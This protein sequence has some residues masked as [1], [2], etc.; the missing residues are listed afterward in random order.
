M[1][2]CVMFT[3]PAVAIFLLGQKFFIGGASAGAL[4]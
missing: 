3:L 4:K 2:A 1:A